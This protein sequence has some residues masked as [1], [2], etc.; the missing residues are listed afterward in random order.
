L[1]IDGE[2]SNTRSCIDLVAGEV[3]KSP[4]TRVY[5]VGIGTS[6]SREL[7]SG[8]ASSGRGT[9]EFVRDSADRMQAKVLSQLKRTE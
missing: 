9:A 1:S 8:L 5:T 7:V 4:T 2:V 6:V 3:K